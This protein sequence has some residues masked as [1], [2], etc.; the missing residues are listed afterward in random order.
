MVSLVVAFFVAA[1]IIFAIIYVI[2]V[3]IF[4]KKKRAWLRSL[5]FFI[6]FPTWDVLIAFIIF[7]PSA[8]FWSGDTIHEKVKTDTIYYDIYY[9]P[10]GVY[11][12]NKNNLFYK[13]F[14]YVEMDI[15][16]NASYLPPKG[17][18]RFWLGKDRN[19]KYK[20]ISEIGARYTIKYKKPI[21]LPIIPIKFGKMDIID[22]KENKVIAS[23]KSVAVSY[24]HLFKFPFFNWLRWYDDIGKFIVYSNK[25]NYELK[26]R[27]I[28]SD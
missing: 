23:R 25:N 18:Y 10:I 24:L 19:I 11:E 13:N 28:N 27:V 2:L 3:K 9:Q 1:Y 12:G 8:L 16:K 14:K 26:T 22:R 17:L 5:I 7:I 20:K 21:K 4:S 15:K 6:L